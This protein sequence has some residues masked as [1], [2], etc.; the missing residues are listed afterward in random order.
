M[1][2]SD[3]VSPIIMV[4]L[5]ATDRVWRSVEEG[6][7]WIHDDSVRFASVSSDGTTV[8]T[9]AVARGGWLWEAH[10]SEIVGGDVAVEGS[11]ERALS[12]PASADGAA[13][14]S[15]TQF[16]AVLS[17]SENALFVIGG[18][19]E[20]AKPTADLWQ[21]DPQTRV[22]LNRPLSGVQ[23]NAVLAATI[24]PESRSLYVVD[25][26]KL[27]WMRWARLLEIDLASNQSRLVGLWPRHS[28]V[29]AVFL[30]SGPDGQLVLAGSSSSRKQYLGVVFQPSKPGLLSIQAVFSGRGVLG[31]RPTLDKRGLTLPLNTDTGVTNTFLSREQ[32]SRPGFGRHLGECL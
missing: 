30:S 3:R 7:N 1:D 10:P 16:G 22:W 24:R 25:E 13:P 21:Y 29:D 20:N 27:G 11:A 6:G 28:A 5:A 18:I 32:L 4:E 19:G 31:V 8:G 23:P 17:A 26:V 9:V 14:S 12:A 2:V 15:R